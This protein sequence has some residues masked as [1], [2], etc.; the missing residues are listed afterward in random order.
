MASLTFDNIYNNVIAG[1]LIH[2]RLNFKWKPSDKI[3]GVVE[4]R[5]RLIWGDAVRQNTD[6]VISLRNREE[7]VN[8][9]KIWVSDSSLVLLTNTERLYVDFRDKKWNV[10]LGRQRINWGVTTIWNPNDIFNVYNYFDFDY[11]ER[12]GADAGKVKYIFSDFSNLELVYA[13]TG[14]KDASVAALRYSLNRWRYDMHLIAGWYKAYPTIG[15]GWAGNIKDAGFKGEAQIFIPPVDS[16]THL[17]ITMESDYM[18]KKGWY[19]NIA[20]LF[21]NYG[22]DKP[23]ENLQNVVNIQFSPL[24]LMPTKY[25]FAITIAK[26][27]TPLFK[28]TISTIYAPGTNLLILYPTL[29]YNIATD[30]DVSLIWQSF[31]S[32]MENNYLSLSQSGYLRF[33]WSF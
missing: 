22:L 28:G 7:A 27:F 8:L 19:L 20:F 6:F 33:K 4:F 14:Q 24:H 11:E 10:R 31:F 15:A 12:P 26:Q 21:A 13:S 29:Q 5:N 25:N 9:Q 1:D 23:I 3:T 30:W 18:F 32:Q 2:N 16:S 17:N